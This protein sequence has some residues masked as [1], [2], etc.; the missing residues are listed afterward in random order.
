MKETVKVR[1]Q[2]R[3]YLSWPLLLSL[4]LIFGNIGVTAVSK[5]GGLV[6][7]P[8][9]LCYMAIA[10]WIYLYRRRYILRGLVEFSA[11]YAWIQKQLLSEMAVPYGLADEEGRLLWINDAFQEILTEKKSLRKNLLTIFPEVTKADLS[12]EEAAQIHTTYQSRK[13][14]IDIRPVYVA[15]DEDDE[16]AIVADNQKMLAVYLFDETEIL[17]YRQEITDEKMVAGLIYLDNYE[18]AL[19]SVEEV[20]RSLLTALIDRKS[21]V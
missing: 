6:L 16:N 9:T 12:A 17:R 3:Q 5:A 8:F 11:E 4:F 1:G 7:F 2:L 10:A 21:V 15:G 14:R 18:E 19:E 20:R 13:F